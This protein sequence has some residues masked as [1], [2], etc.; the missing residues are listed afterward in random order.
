VQLF[1]TYGLGQ[2]AIHCATMPNLLTSDAWLEQNWKEVAPDVFS[3]EHAIQ[4]YEQ[5]T[6][7]AF[8]LYARTKFISTVNIINEFYLASQKIPGAAKAQDVLGKTVR[9]ATRLGNDAL[10]ETA[11]AAAKGTRVLAGAGRGM[12]DALSRKR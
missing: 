4:S 10:T 12:L 2:F 9:R 7:K 5:F 3:G 1:E 6:G 11:R 8:P